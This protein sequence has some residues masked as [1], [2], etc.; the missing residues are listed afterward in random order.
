MPMK[1][2][3]RLSICAGLG[4]PAAFFLQIGRAIVYE[5]AYFAHHTDNVKAILTHF[6]EKMKCFIYKYE[7][8][9]Q[10]YIIIAKM[11]CSSGDESIFDMV[12]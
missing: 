4:I 5:N 1:Q 3:T 10:N 7:K 2:G 11:T 9:A 8:S 6:S 12:D